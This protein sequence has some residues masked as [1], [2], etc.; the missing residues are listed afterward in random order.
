MF[1]ENSNNIF[2]KGEIRLEQKFHFGEVFETASD[3]IKN[4]KQSIK[5]AISLI[6]VQSEALVSILSEKDRKLMNICLVSFYHLH[7]ATST[8]LI[9]SFIINALYNLFH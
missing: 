3:N 6:M 4:S 9:N 1:N 5:Y 2:F 8:N 7:F